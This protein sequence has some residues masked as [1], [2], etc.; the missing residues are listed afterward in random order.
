[1]RERER[2]RDSERQRERE[3][4]RE[5]ERGRGGGRRWTGTSKHFLC[6]QIKKKSQESTLMCTI[7]ASIHD[8]TLE[9]FL[10]QIR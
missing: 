1:M 10:S 6:D 3:R 2:E 5:R 7:V 8:P 4:E 9:F